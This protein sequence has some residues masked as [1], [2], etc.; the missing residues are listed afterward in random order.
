M[1]LPAERK[2]AL[3]ILRET[4]KQVRSCYAMSGIG[5]GHAWPSDA[6]SGTDLGHT[7]VQDGIEEVAISSDQ[8]RYG[9]R[10][11]T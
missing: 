9:T 3:K 5:L 7:A 1:V 4:V 8:A 6:M 2:I 10:R 11:E